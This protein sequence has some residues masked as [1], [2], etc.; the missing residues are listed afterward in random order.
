M[1]FSKRTVSLTLSLSFLVAGPKSYDVVSDDLKNRIFEITRATG[2]NSRKLLSKIC[3]DD[4]SNEAL[5]FRDTRETF[6]GGVPVILN[7][8]SFSGELGYSL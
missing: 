3:R 7:R 6:V 4:V 8:I 1:Y 2:P 5:K